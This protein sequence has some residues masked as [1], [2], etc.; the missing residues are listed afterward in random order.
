MNVDGSLQI[1][2]VPLYAEFCMV[3]VVYINFNYKNRLHK[4]IK[5][6]RF[7]FKDVFAI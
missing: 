2:R 3:L 4:I 5:Y 1:L 6:S 7:G